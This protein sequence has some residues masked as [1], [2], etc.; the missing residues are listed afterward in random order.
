[1]LMLS[2]MLPVPLDRRPEE[3]LGQMIAVTLGRIDH[4]DAKLAGS[5]D[6]PV[7]PRPG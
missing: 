7:N 5:P 2:V 4:V 1:M 3:R 6:Q